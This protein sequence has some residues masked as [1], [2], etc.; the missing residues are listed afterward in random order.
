MPMEMAQMAPEILDLGI[1]DLDSTCTG[2]QLQLSSRLQFAPSTENARTDRLT[3]Q[4]LT[5][6]FSQG[7]WIRH[8][9]AFKLVVSLRLG[10]SVQDVSALGVPHALATAFQNAKCWEQLGMLPTG[11]TTSMNEENDMCLLT[12]CLADDSTPSKQPKRCNHKLS[13][14]VAPDEVQ[15]PPGVQSRS[16]ETVHLAFHLFCRQLGKRRKLDR[17]VDSAREPSIETADDSFSWTTQHWPCE[18]LCQT[19]DDDRPNGGARAD[20]ESGL[21]ERLLQLQ[22]SFNPELIDDSTDHNTMTTSAYLGNTSATSVRKRTLSL[23]G[24][25][26]HDITDAHSS[27]IVLELVA[28]AVRAAI[29]GVSGSLPKGFRLR[30]A[31]EFASLS[32]LAPATWS[33][34]YNTAISSRAVLLPTLTHALANIADKS[35][36]VALRSAISRLQSLGSRARQFDD[37]AHGALT[38]RLWQMLRTALY[39]ESAARRLDLIPTLTPVICPSACDP[40]SDLFATGWNDW[41]DTGDI[42]PGAMLDEESERLHDHTQDLG[43]DGGSAKGGLGGLLFDDQEDIYSEDRLALLSDPI[44]GRVEISDS[45]SY[46]SMDLSATSESY[47][48]CAKEDELLS[49]CESA[50]SLSLEELSRADM[51]GWE[52]HADPHVNRSS[53]DGR[54]GSDLFA[55]ADMDVV[56]IR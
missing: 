44:D 24:G 54:F 18:G 21:D 15:L 37:T 8:A 2:L 36:S 9:T 22:E 17:R 48:S 3:L 53:A 1:I 13:R 12:I 40:R 46:D 23:V 26:P 30:N 35:R 10:D 31:G 16:L 55:E 4:A 14:G 47:S 19:K 11:V 29:S 28:V 52:C 49:V 45:I 38:A 5:S 51:V 41:E 43:V 34:G 56:D 7:P 42:G 32:E 33:P 50:D 39:D 25:Y 27:S 20:F 6:P